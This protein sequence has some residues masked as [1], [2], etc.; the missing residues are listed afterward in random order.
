M[1]LDLDRAFEAYN[2][3]FDGEI[4][5][6]PVG[7]FSKFDN[8]MVQRLKK[9]EFGQRLADYLE[10]HTTVKRILAQGATICDDVCLEFQERASWLVIQAPNI[11]EMF[12]GE[13]GDPSV[14]TGETPS[15]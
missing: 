1:D 6:K 14:A 10:M 13:V 7:S 5:S 3:R 4:G 15:S 9:D 2:A 8:V 11:L 12:K